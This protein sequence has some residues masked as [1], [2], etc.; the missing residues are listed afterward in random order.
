MHHFT[1]KSLR[2]IVF[3]KKTDLTVQFI[4]VQHS[5]FLSHLQVVSL[6]LTQASNTPHVE[7]TVV[8]TS[9]R[10]RGSVK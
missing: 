5:P 2:F 4:F 3:E 8:L 10:D 1:P 9:G 7:H 6:S